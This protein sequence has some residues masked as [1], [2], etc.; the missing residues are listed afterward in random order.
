MA[1]GMSSLVSLNLAERG[2][3]EVICWFENATL[4]SLVCNAV[5]PGGKGGTVYI[6]L[7]N[8]NSG[9][10]S[11]RGEIGGGWIYADLGD[12]SGVTRMVD[13]VGIGIIMFSRV[14]GEEDSVR[15]A[16]VRVTCSWR[17]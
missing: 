3:V 17:M 7:V 2:T 12:G 11:G 1:L 6:V 13:R 16:S 10:D 15:L 8:D 5:V 14:N 4:P 9:F